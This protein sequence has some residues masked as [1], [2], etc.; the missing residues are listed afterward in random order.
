MP[1]DSAQ[2]RRGPHDIFFVIDGSASI[3]YF[4]F[5]KVQIFLMDLITLLRVEPSE[6]NT[7]LMQF[8]KEDQTSI[9]WDLGR[10]NEFELIMYLRDM[11][12]QAGVRTA[13]GDALTRVNNEVSKNCFTLPY[14]TLPYLTLPYLTLPY[15]TLPYLTLPYLTLPYLTL[16]Y[17]T[18]PYLTLPYLTLPY[19]TL[20]YLTLPSLNSFSS[21]AG[22][23]WTTWRPSRNPRHY[24]SLY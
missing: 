4:N 23:H 5:E 24:N 2:C 8:S 12:Y 21:I 16:P 22:L 1:R 20:P 3:K 15:L 7:G 17:L 9:I 19:L 11:K 13:T 18:L 6:I 14:L 10:Y